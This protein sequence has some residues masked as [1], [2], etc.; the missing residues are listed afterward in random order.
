MSKAIILFSGG[1]DSVL[2]LRRARQ[3]GL[4]VV[5]ACNAHFDVE[6]AIHADVY[7]EIAKSCGIDNIYQGR[8]A[9]DEMVATG[10]LDRFI[11]VI[12]PALEAHPGIDTMIIGTDGSQGGIMML[13]YTRMAEALGLS[14]YVPYLMDY[15]EHFFTDMEEANLYLTVVGYPKK[16]E[17]QV[18]VLGNISA[19]EFIEARQS[20]NQMVYS[21]V[22]TVV[23]NGDL[24]SYPVN[25]KLDEQLS[26]IV[27]A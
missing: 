19:K 7:A 16:V 3:D 10:A 26:Q 18:E 15:D 12:K 11:S 22:Q 20:D 23:T 25:I 6:M 24:F 4:E 27:L 21:Q 17:G 2:A 5:A 8:L 9:W 1:K 13:F 14:I